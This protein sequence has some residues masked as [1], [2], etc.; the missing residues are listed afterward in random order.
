MVWC[1]LIK[2]PSIIIWCTSRNFFQV[3]FLSHQLQGWV[4]EWTSSTSTSGTL[5]PQPGAT[6]PCLLQM[7]PWRVSS[8][9]TTWKY[10]AIELQPFFPVPEIFWM[11]IQEFLMILAL[12]SLLHYQP[13]L[14]CTDSGKEK[15]SILDISGEIHRASI[16]MVHSYLV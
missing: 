4:D 5:C 10:E 7:Q 3:W 6:C 2:T 15:C 12:A 1:M 13:V 11:N 14:L 9:P 8:V 16:W